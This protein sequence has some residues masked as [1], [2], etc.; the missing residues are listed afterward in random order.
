MKFI[1][2]TE[3][4]AAAGDGGSGIASFLRERGKPRG[5]PNGG[6]GGKGGDVLVTADRRVKT[7]LALRR[8]RRIEA[9]SG[10]RGEGGNCTGKAGKD[11]GLR[12]PIGTRFCDA[13]TGRL[14]ADLARD[15]ETAILARGG[16]G[17]F[18]NTRFKS[19]VNRA[20]RRATGGESGEERRFALELR[21][22]ADVGLLG[23]PNAGKSSL[24]RALSAAKPKVA[25]YPFTTLSPQL[26]V[27]GEED[28]EALTV[29]D[30]PGLIGGAA[31]G[32]GLGNRFLRHLART[33]L[34]CH[35]VD[36]SARDPAG[37]CLQ[38]QKELAESGLPLPQKPQCLVLNKSDMLPARAQ[39]KCRA[40]MRRRFPNFLQCHVVSALSGAGTG[41]LSRSLLVHHASRAE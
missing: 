9:Q 26:G 31:H 11:A 15:G 41:E 39:Q 4:I 20:P 32:A 16:R 18:G 21:I 10:R 35:V 3:I 22:L 40:E 7:L 14:H 36:M 24:L 5:G 19:S 30:V 8:M 29:A 2:E 28:G 6:D 38:V 23:L 13:D 37:D 12:V 33:A 1:D 17:G 34:L 27:I 25:S